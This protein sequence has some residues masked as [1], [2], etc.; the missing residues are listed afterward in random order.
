MISTVQAPPV[1]SNR[2]P[3]RATHAPT[4]PVPPARA[5]AP[6]WNPLEVFGTLLTTS[7]CIHILVA[8]F[9]GFGINPD[10]VRQLK[11][12]PPP[13]RILEDVKLEPPRPAPKDEAPPPEAPPPIS[14][15]AVAAS[16]DLP[17]LPEVTEISAVPANVAVAF[18]LPVSG[19]V[20]IVKDAAHASGAVGGRRTSSGPISVNAGEAYARFLLL[21]TLT[22]PTVALQR[23]ISGSVEVEFKTT[24]TGEI[25]EIKVRTGSGHA[26]L[27]NAALQNMHRGRWT[28][29]AGYFVKNFV[30]VL[31]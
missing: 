22:Y 10:P 15:P 21:P 12:E 3:V 17:P 29:E 20:R 1:R 4:R 24:P 31:N 19:P 8:G 30:F 2:R 16:I 6:K 26:E 18:A 11:T 28:G 13:T 23:R 9:S 25:Y 14:G 27:D 5:A 7:A